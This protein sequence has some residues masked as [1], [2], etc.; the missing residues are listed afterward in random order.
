MCRLLV[1]ITLTRLLIASIGVMPIHYCR[2]FYGVLSIRITSRQTK[3]CLWL[4]LQNAL[5]IL[6]LS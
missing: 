4:D 3:N 5:I 2:L 1:T 6:A